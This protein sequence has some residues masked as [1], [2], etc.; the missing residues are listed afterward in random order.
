MN[1][2]AS[3]DS[4]INSTGLR[5]FVLEVARQ[6]AGTPADQQGKIRFIRGMGERYA[7]I[8]PEDMGHPLRFLR[9]MAGAPPVQLGVDGFRTDILDDYNPARHYTAFVW[10]GFWLPVPLAIAVLYLWEAASF[11]RYRGEW[12][13]KDILSGY[14]GVRHGTAVRRQGCTVLPHLIAT[15]LADPEQVDVE[16]LLAEVNAVLTAG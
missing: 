4:S 14:I 13:Q 2:P 6:A 12:S 11:V 5:R 1:K 7:Y 3:P 9:Q 16:E 8:R 15:E 10:T